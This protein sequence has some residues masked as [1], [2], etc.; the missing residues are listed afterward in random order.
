MLEYLNN[1]L[2]IKNE[3]SA[4]IVVS[5]IVF[6]I[7]GFVKIIISR[8]EIATKRKRLKKTF[9]A[10]ITK[11]ISDLKSREINA[12]EF[13]QNLDINKGKVRF[14]YAITPMSYLEH[15]YQMNYDE[16]Y[17]A[18]TSY[19]FF[20]KRV[21]EKSFHRIWE[22]LATIKT[23]DEHIEINVKS[24]ADNYKVAQN[25]YNDAIAEYKDEFDGIKRKHSGQRLDEEMY[26]FI[27]PLN[28]IWK[29]FIKINAQERVLF[30]NSYNELILPSIALIR[31]KSK[32]ASS[33][34]LDKPLM[35]CDFFY[36]KME[37]SLNVYQSV[38][39][40]DYI[41][42]RKSKRLLKRIKEII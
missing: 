15:F 5:L 27:N 7:G 26:N 39:R 18:Y 8:I 25:G 13:Y 14:T 2:G 19:S 36:K 22:I 11:T 6:I 32:I 4:P 31:S 34:N 1:L 17:L 12:K 9:E 37:D 23:V 42:Y 20:S 35:K 41:V 40:N 24:M 3:I 16:L 29:N 30:N 10:I 21:K 28:N 33:F 38:F